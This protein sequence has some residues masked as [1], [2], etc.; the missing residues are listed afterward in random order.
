MQALPLSVYGFLRVAHSLRW[1]DCRSL[2][3]VWSFFFD[4]YITLCK[5]GEE[6]LVEGVVYQFFKLLGWNISSGDKDLSFL[7][8]FRA[9]GVDISFKL[10]IDGRLFFQNTE[11]RIHEDPWCHHGGV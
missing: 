11:E 6:S 8:V 3:L 10:W 1:L 2:G 7:D 9:L 5:Q 4:D